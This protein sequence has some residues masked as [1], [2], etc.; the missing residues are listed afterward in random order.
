[1]VKYLQHKGSTLPTFKNSVL[2]G[3]VKFVCIV[4]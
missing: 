3:K 4:V 2:S 1:M